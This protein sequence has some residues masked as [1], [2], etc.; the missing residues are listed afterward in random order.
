MKITIG[1]IKIENFKGI[2]SLNSGFSDR[3]NIQGDN[4]TCKTSI[5]DAAMW[6]LFGMN[7]AGSEFKVRPLD[8]NNQVVEKLCTSVEVD[9]FANGFCSSFKRELSEKRVDNKADY[10]VN[11]VPCKLSE[12]NAKLEAICCIA[13]WKLLMSVDAF[14]KLDTKSARKKLQE[15]AGD[16]PEEHSDANLASDYPAV[17]KAFEDRKDLVELAKEIAVKQKKAIDRKEMIPTEINAQDKLKVVDVDFQALRL[18]SESIERSIATIDTQLQHSTTTNSSEQEAV[19]AQSNKLRDLSTELADIE[20]SLHREYYK[21]KRELED[22]VQQ[23]KSKI[24]QQQNAIYAID[25]DIKSCEATKV[26]AEIAKREIVARWKIENEKVFCCSTTSECPTCGKIYT[27]EELLESSNTQIENF[28]IA[29]VKVLEDLAAQVKSRVDAI[30]SCEA[31]HKSLVDSKQVI[32]KGV[33][34]L[35]SSIKEL[36]NKIGNILPFDTFKMANSEFKSVFQKIEDQRGVV[37]KMQ[38]PE[39]KA[40]VDM[41]NEKGELQRRLKAV[42]SDLASERTNHNIEKMK[43][44]LLEEEDLL[45]QT[46]ADYKSTL[47]QIK[48]FQKRKIEIVERRISSMF[49]LIKFKMYEQNLTNDSEKEICEAL[50]DGVPYPNLN[51]ANRINAGIDFLN[52]YGRSK[53]VT[54]PIFVDG[55]ESVVKLIETSAQV[56]TMQVV[57][58]MPLT[59][60]NN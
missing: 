50:I 29:K 25:A 35:N 40:D 34:A 53:G 26:K 30:A 60:I 51:T 49:S 42:L 22:K 47:F 18:E 19:D 1:S 14:F 2:K 16:I 5:H 37:K 31:T 6:C 10:Y 7:G 15:M 46:I 33:E 55:K 57:E 9:L 52:A 21:I 8:S 17:I 56:I 3:V 48:E 28:N 39:N 23:T 24:S 44:T 12:F 45:Q 38:V 58:G 41:Q 27:E 59:I 13:D 36:T 32:E 54:A 20:S 11:D 4:G 43:A